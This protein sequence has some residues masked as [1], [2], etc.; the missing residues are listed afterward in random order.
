MEWTLNIIIASIMLVIFVVLLAM[1]FIGSM[2]DSFVFRP[3]HSYLS[4]TQR[5]HKDIRVGD[6][7]TRWF[8]NAAD[9]ILFYLHG[10]N[11]NISDREYVAE[12]A[13]LS[14][15]NLVLIDYRGYGM[16]N[17][18]A[19]LANMREDADAVMSVIRQQYNDQNIIIMSESLGSIPASYLAAHYAVRGVIVLSG[20]SSFND[21]ADE[22]KGIMKG[23]LRYTISGMGNVE[24]NA[25]LL[26]RT[27]SPILLAHSPEDEIVTFACAKKNL[28]AC[29][30]ARLV[31]IGGGHATPVISEENLIALLEFAGI[32]THP[33]K[34]DRWRTKMRTIG[35]ILSFY[36]IDM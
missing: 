30:Q 11:G 23:I 3:T 1:I 2:R 15:L 32:Q 10:N 26:A 16:S 33:N 20:I 6:V 13:E 18:H 34:Y 21:M 7:M 8:D 24:T 22:F 14:H 35:H 31:V 36:V 25:Q 5:E 29:P 27:Q 4:T 19:S 9:A 28:E 12:F 17:G